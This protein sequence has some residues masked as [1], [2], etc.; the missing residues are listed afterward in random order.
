MQT[1]PN[2]NHVKPEFIRLP[3]P[4]ARCP[5]TGLSRTTLTELTAPSER[6]GH[7]PPVRSIVLKGRHA[8]RGIRLIQYQS[9]IDHL[10]ALTS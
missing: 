5:I 1:T 8:V 2:N 4:G 9:L 3:K 10:N 7:R 6:N